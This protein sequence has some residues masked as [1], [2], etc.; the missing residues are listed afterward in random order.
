MWRGRKAQRK[1]EVFSLASGFVHFF[2]LDDDDDHPSIHPIRTKYFKRIFFL[3]QKTSFSSWAF[4]EAVGL[5]ADGSPPVSVLMR[6][7]D[8]KTV[9]SALFCTQACSLHCQDISKDVQARMTHSPA[10]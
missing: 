1:K 4:E 9:F 5:A 6:L 7:S 3:L 10:P 2:F 8:S